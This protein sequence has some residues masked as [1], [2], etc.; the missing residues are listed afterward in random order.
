[1]LHR[2]LMELLYIYSVYYDATVSSRLVASK[3]KV[4]LLKPMT[5][6][7]LEPAGAVLVLRL[8]QHINTC[9]WHG[10]PMQSVTFYFDSMDVLWWIWGHGQSFCPFVANHIGEIQMVTQCWDELCA[11]P[12]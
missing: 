6:P 1:M 5:V 11:T 7:Q 8:T 4:A 10:L 9:T 12:D 2:K 3:C